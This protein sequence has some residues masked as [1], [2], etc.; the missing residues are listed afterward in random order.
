MQWKELLQKS[1]RCQTALPVI[2]FLL[3]SLWLAFPYFGFG[4]SSFVWLP[5]NGDALLPMQLARADGLVREQMGAWGHLFVSGTDGLSSLWIGEPPYLLFTLLPGW[6]AY[7]LTM[8]CQRFVAGYFTFRLV[9]DV[10]ALDALPSLYAGLTYAL[11]CQGSINHQWAGFT[12]YDGLALPGLPF[13][14]WSLHR[15]AS[16][17]KAL[18]YAGA[19]GMG[20]LLSATSF[21]FIAVFLFPA[22]LCWFLCV[23]PRMQRSFWMAFLFF[24]LSWALAES[25]V[26][27]ACYLNSPVSFRSLWQFDTPLTDPINLWQYQISLA[28]ALI[29]DNVLSIALA[30]LGLTLPE[31]RDRRLIILSGFLLF[32]LVYKM[33]YPILQKE[34]LMNLGVLKGFGFDR[35]F[36]LI[37]FLAA[38]SG[39]MGLHVLGSQWAIMVMRGSALLRSLALQKLVFAVAIGL[40]CL[41]S[42][43][44]QKDILVEMSEGKNF[45]TLYRNPALM[46]LAE[47]RDP[48][49]PYRTATVAMSDRD[50]YRLHPGYA[51]AYGLETADGYINLYSK[52]YH[53]FWE[54]LI[55]PMS[56]YDAEIFNR[57]RYGGHRAYLSVPSGDPP[58]KMHES[59]FPEYFRLELLSLAN[60]RFILSSGPLGGHGLTLL[61]SDALDAQKVWEK[62]PRRD[63]FLGLLDGTYPGPP[64]YIYENKQVI[65]RFFLARHVQILQEDTEVLSA[66]SLATREDLATTAYLKRS[67]LEGLSFP[68]GNGKGG[69]VRVRDYQADRLVLDVDARSESILVVTNNY[70]PFWKAAVDGRD[71][72]IFPVDH[73]FQG[74]PVPRGRHEVVLT[75]EP[76]YAM[77]P[78]LPH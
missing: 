75:Y 15:L 38:V 16:C 23:T 27:W 74:L 28:F 78:R 48:A 25:Q 36:L 33:G 56:R 21:Y 77:L 55:S 18:L 10:L 11:F 53:Q 61:P 42:A 59:P 57:F 5:D 29:R 43:M 76:P 40:L 72:R 47:Q 70:S 62:R 26:L 39:A 69:A 37:P 19:A 58:E 4:P 44:I 54:R 71:S 9:K 49:E 8:G 46:R 22:I 2:V 63:K 68:A 7:G 14:I 17:R 1:L 31:K 13:F 32:C 50:G 30:L 67:D 65:P 20:L 66:L 34:V 52:R 3:W 6:L 12:L 64:L 51:W 24:V 60:V 41:Q 45:R 35:L 73:T